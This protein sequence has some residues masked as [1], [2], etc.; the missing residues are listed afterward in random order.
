MTRIAILSNSETGG[1]AERSMNLLANELSL[2]GQDVRLIFMKNGS[3]DAV[4]IT[5]PSVCLNLKGRINLFDIFLGWYRLRKHLISFNPEV[6]IL[7]CDLPEFFGAISALRNRVFVV[8][9]NSKPWVTRKNIGFI[10]RILLKVKRVNWVAVS[11]VFKIW[12]FNSEPISVIRNPIILASKDQI[13]VANLE[14]LVF[15][16]RLTYQKNPEIIL[17]LAESLNMPALFFGEGDL[18]YELKKLAFRKRVT[19]DFA[20][21]VMNPWAHLRQ[22]D[23]LVLPS[24]FEGDA[25]V[26]VEA[27]AHN[28]P[29]LLSDIPE[30]KSLGLS[31]LNYAGSFDDY[32]YKISSNFDL[33]NFQVDQ[34]IRNRI[35]SERSPRFVA[36]RWLEI[37]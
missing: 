36:H 23:L 21:F 5:C 8:E 15:I 27:I 6:T 28:V 37:I 26:P 31:E 17:N 12:P 29:I 16:G 11:D 7:N 10:T 24:R 4:E 2:L 25:L 34:T 9:H 13:P 30:F 3:K 14:R 1:G 18:N 20:G 33:K 35:L 22:G 19:A 32:L